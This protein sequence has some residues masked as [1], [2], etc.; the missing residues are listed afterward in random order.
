MSLLEERDG[1]VFVS[2]LDDVGYGDADH[3]CAPG[4]LPK[5]MAVTML[6]TYPRSDECPDASP[7]CPRARRLAGRIRKR[8]CAEIA[9]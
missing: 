4:S 1:L 9:S 3:A 7:S 6:E 2:R 8:C 5:V